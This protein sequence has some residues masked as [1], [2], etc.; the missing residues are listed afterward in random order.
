M[1]R[2]LLLLR[3]SDF[4]KE[5]N[6]WTTSYINLYNN[7]SYSNYSYT[8]STGGLNLIGDRTYVGLDITSPNFDGEN[9][10]PFSP[11]SIYVTDAGEVV[12]DS[13][14]PTILRF[15]DT[16]SKIDLVNYRYVFTNLPGE[17][18]PGFSI[19][20][21]ES[22]YSTGPWMK[23]IYG[24][25][26]GTI[27]SSGVK[28][29]IRIEL[30]LDDQGIDLG[31]VGLVFY[32]EVAIHDTVPK[33]ISKSAREILDRFPSWTKL[34]EDSRYGATP[35]LDVP[36]SIG[37]KMIN[38]L[39]GM[40]LDDLERR[41]DLTSINSYINSADENMTA[42]VY[43]SYGIPANS[44]RVEGDSVVLARVS[45][46][47]ELI[48]LR[49]T[50]YAY[51]ID[52]TMGQ[53]VTNR[54]FSVLK[55]DGVPVKQEPIN[56]YNS[57]DEF[58]AR[59]GLPR[60]Y[61]ESNFNY[62]KRILDASKNI[63]GVTK[64]ALQV[65]LRRELDIWR[66][67]G[68]TPDS[69]YVGATPEILEIEDIQSSTPYF[70]KYGHPN[71]I[72][73]NL[74]EDINIKYPSNIGYVNWGEGIWDYGGITGQGI[75]RI[76]AIYDSLVNVSNEYYKPGVGD[77]DDAK[78]YFGYEDSA[79]INFSGSVKIEGMQA[80]GYRDLYAPITVPYKM[81]IGYIK[82]IIEQPISDPS[83]V[84]EINVD[85]Y[86]DIATP[87]SFY[88][89]LDA[90]TYDGLRHTNT[91]SEGHPTSPDYNV[92]EVFDHDGYTV[93]YLDFRNK[94]N[95]EQYISYGSTPEFSRV[96]F[97]NINSV[98]V[99]FGFF[100]DQSIQQYVELQPN[101][102]YKY[103]YSTSTPYWNVYN[104]P[105]L[106]WVQVGSDIDGEATYDSSGVSL[107]LS[108]DG[109]RLAVGATSN[110]GINGVNSGHVRVFDWDGSSWVQVGSDIDGEAA[111][112]Y[113][114]FSVDLSSDGNR[115]AVGAYNNDGNG[116]D[117]GHVRVFD[118]DGS[119]WI[120]VGSDIDGE[121]TYDSS[122]VSLALSSDGSRL[123]VGADFNNGIN[124][125][126]S[127]HV[128][129]Y[130]W[131]G[132]SWVQVGSDIDGEAA[133]DYFGSFVD[134]SSDGSRLAVGANYNNGING[135]S[136]GHVRVFDWDGSSW[137]QVGSD[138]DGEAADDLSGWSVDLSSNGNRLAVGAIHNDGNGV[139]SGH[140]RVFDWDG[141]N[142]IQVGSDIDGEAAGDLSGWS[143]GLSSDGNRLAVG[144]YNNDGNGTNSGHV[145]VFDWDGSS[146]VQVGSDIDGEA[147][148][149]LSGWSVDLSSDGNR[150]AVGAT[151]NDG[152]GTDSGHVRVFD[153]DGSYLSVNT[154]SLST[155]NFIL[156][157]LDLLIGSNVYSA[158][159]V[160]FNSKPIKREVVLNSYSSL[161]DYDLSHVDLN[162]LK[163]I[164]SILLP[165]G[166]T[167]SSIYID[168]IMD[169][170]TGMYGGVC[171]DPVTEERFFVP[172]SPSIEYYVIAESATV[173]SSYFESSTLS[174]DNNYYAFI[175]SVDS[176]H[177]PI[178]ARTFESF[179]SETT[180][181]LYYGYIDSFG[182]A[183]SNNESPL[184]AYYNE[185]KL[186]GN[187]R[188]RLD[189][190]NLS[191]D[192]YRIIE[193]I[194]FITN[195]DDVI[196]Y[197][198]DIN[199]LRLNL[200]NNLAN[201]N[202]TNF[203]LYAERDPY[204]DRDYLASVNSGLINI[205]KNDQ[206]IYSDSISDV[207]SNSQNFQ[208]TLSSVPRAG[209]PII[210][211]VGSDYY[212]NV[213]FQDLA[214][215]HI[216]S[217]YNKEIIYGN[218]YNLIH[219][220]YQD[221]HIEYVKDLF[222]GKNI[223]SNIDVPGYSIEL[224]SD[225]TPMVN[226]RAY[227]VSYMVNKAY[228]IDKDFYD[229]LSD[230]Y[231]ARLYLS[232]TPNS[233]EDYV[234]TYENSTND[235]K[236]PIDLR[237]DAIENPLDEGFVYIDAIE[238]DF[239]SADIYLSPKNISDNFNDFMYL[240]IVSKDINGNLKPNQ[241]FWISSSSVLADPSYIVTDD[242]GVGKAILRYSGSIPSD[243]ISDY[244][245][246]EGDDPATPPSD[247]YGY[248][249]TVN[250]SIKNSVEFIVSVKAVPLRLHYSGSGS[251]YV[252]IIGQI[253]WRDK[254]LSA[255]LDINW[256][257]ADTL[258]DIFATPNYKYSGTVKSNADG[259]FQVFDSILADPQINPGTS[260]AVVELA[261]P[262]EARSIVVSLG[263][264]FRDNLITIG[265]D[266]VY[267]HE[268]YDPVQYAN[269]VPGFDSALGHLK[270]E[271]SDLYSTPNFVYK[272]SD[273]SN[274]SFVNSGYNW[275]PPRWVPISRYEQYQ[276]GIL[277]STPNMISDYT[278]I[279]PDS[280]EQ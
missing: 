162:I 225:A 77:F 74:I 169:T 221:T 114:G 244:I 256:Y 209:S 68:A 34:Y 138:I 228:F 1:K 134:L 92:F 64:N 151:S 22:D 102:D 200:Q 55:V 58:G 36:E 201:G 187:Y 234:I 259:S 277:G 179:S 242:N 270:R 127:G 180:P 108:S 47:S 196:Q 60:L 78:L 21:Y 235:F 122:G 111:Y 9:A 261:T 250:Y 198:D 6:I 46:F 275:E 273:S 173:A 104:F 188:L 11:N 101:L 129:V 89:N 136:S 41:I 167:P 135:F 73:R 42:W 191:E 23:T 106:S 87:A 99:V 149:D 65:G 159:P 121:A 278:Q 83:F 165:G 28:P 76:P 40:H 37:G 255:E 189:S 82:N 25:D 168:G 113:S 192:S 186:V 133:D 53:L 237:I 268:S 118:W 48:N 241:G 266:I 211:K 49:V 94:I 280:S 27:L 178:K 18:T 161:E 31:S 144:A 155:P 124:G 257:V 212:R 86:G 246:I 43:S 98:S 33:N 128:R 216:H 218:I 131:D 253:Y 75:S 141:S 12:Y 240:T 190:F 45:N 210:V 197:T 166:A 51:Y 2:Y 132:S 184:D 30:T 105:A 222:L 272:H 13:A 24:G 220:A 227:E 213:F 95:N 61:L 88:V 66:A 215:P 160:Y 4:V 93:R 81:S 117:S 32:L 193:K 62:K 38:A 157:D 126:S 7:N 264:V 17:H 100:W 72:F 84:Y 107:A 267:W 177:Y 232:S 67:Y 142:W 10:T 35:A 204:L 199:S 247:T 206:Y 265:G 110:D 116:T 120:Q 229:L 219:L 125:F 56:V 91:Y 183:Y 130:D 70:S 269:E 139:S 39:S 245:L 207:F 224:F 226:G 205:N 97:G 254:P 20:F 15:L 175:R 146:W 263:E 147:A 44:I 79:T 112:D 57:F 153:I 16:S 176:S 119:S 182:N 262:S 5:E 181:G 236:Y 123:A 249:A 150:L 194:L 156:E 154:T 8:R 174:Y 203:N 248:S 163:H 54:I 258:F 69:N 3:S 185:D 208:H 71:K 223:F 90:N 152:N 143:V 115:L 164:D 230:S 202:E 103:S 63:S 252:N 214:T 239:G 231:Q 158:T 243:M 233:P 26:S 29:Y 195:N 238:R 251:V 96:F 137:V 140:V 271:N 260:F 170:V 52:N 217:F 171:F 14:T 19:Q 145:R 85:S 274:V 50:D 148:G 279:H 276:M 172:S 80:S 59:V 109:S